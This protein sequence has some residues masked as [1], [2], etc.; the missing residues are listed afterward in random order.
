MSFFGSNKTGLPDGMPERVKDQT[1]IAGATKNSFSDKIILTPG[2]TM[3]LASMLSGTKNLVVNFFVPDEKH[4]E[5]LRMIFGDWD[6]IS[7]PGKR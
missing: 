4:L 6:K 3:C 1:L 2:R 7:M 5:T